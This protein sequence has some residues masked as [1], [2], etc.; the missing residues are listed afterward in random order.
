VYEL[1]VTRN[2]AT[3]EECGCSIV[4]EAARLCGIVKM[5]EAN[6]A[7]IWAA[8]GGARIKARISDNSPRTDFAWLMGV[9]PRAPLF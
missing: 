5:S 8:C 3:S 1:Q 6:V 9:P 7:R 2:E 4:A